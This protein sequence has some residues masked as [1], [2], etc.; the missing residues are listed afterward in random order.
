MGINSNNDKEKREEARGQKPQT[1]V[2]KAVS[3][4]K[5]KAH[6]VQNGK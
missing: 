3:E 5:E 2:E 1:A 4:T 6:K